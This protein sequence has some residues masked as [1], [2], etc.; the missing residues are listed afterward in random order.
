MLDGFTI[1][2]WVRP[3]PD[4][5]A[6]MATQALENLRTA[7]LMQ[8]RQYATQLLTAP[9]NQETRLAP[10]ETRDFYIMLRS[11]SYVYEVQVECSDPAFPSFEVEIIDTCT[12]E[13]FWETSKGQETFPQWSFDVCKLAPA[14]AGGFIAV[15]I[16]DNRYR[17][18]TPHL[19]EGSGVVLVRITNQA[20]ALLGTTN[21]GLQVA[22]SVSEPVPSEAQIL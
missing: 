20:V 4:R 7:G 12:K 13:T 18:V 16:G 17:L 8:Y 9:P 2:N 10:G 3:F 5:Y 19:V 22:L 1:Q 14:L 15:G 21:S 6:F 11:G